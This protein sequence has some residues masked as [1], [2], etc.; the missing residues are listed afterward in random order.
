MPVWDTD[1]RSLKV[2]DR[3]EDL[4]ESGVQFF[5]DGGLWW[6]AVA[7]EKGRHGE[8]VSQVETLNPGVVEEPQAAFNK[9]SADKP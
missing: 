9:R 2:V 6:A 8:L 3:Q 5:C 7:L 1:V 4:L